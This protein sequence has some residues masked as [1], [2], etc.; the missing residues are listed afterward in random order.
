MIFNIRGTSGS[1]KSH[2][3]HSILKSNEHDEL[4]I[5]NT[6]IVEAYHVTSMDV[7]II[8]RYGS[9][10]GGCDGIPTQDVV[11]GKV[12]RFSDPNIIFEGLL[13]S[14]SF[15]RYHL[16]AKKSGPIIFCFLNTTP[17]KCIERVYQRRVLKGT[18]GKFNED[19]I[20]RDWAAVD[21][22]REKFIEAGHT[23]YQ[24][25]SETS[26]EDFIKI[27]TKHKD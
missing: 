18:T 14:H 15:Q 19:Q 10:C 8:G 3:V 5:P 11:C 25:G 4:F 1:G 13:V 7:N 26:V 6:K 21:R 12:K 22:C 27:Y 20:H 16:L 17:E 23:V 24:L 9:Q 2:I